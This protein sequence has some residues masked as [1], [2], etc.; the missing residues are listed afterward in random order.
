M[1]SFYRRHL[2]PIV[3]GTVLLAQ[4]LG[5]AIQVKR[6][7]DQGSSSVLRLWAVAVFSPIERRFVHSQNWVGDTWRNYFYLR[8]VRKENEELKARLQQLELEQI[9]LREDAN[10]ARRIQSLLQFKEQYINK[11]VAAQVIGTSGSEQ[12]RMIYID[13]GSNDGIKENL[14][15]ISPAGIVGKV[16]RVFPDYSQVLEITDQTSGV[17]VMLTKTRLQGILR[18]TPSGELSLNYIMADEKIES[19]EEIVTSGGDRIF[20]KGLPVG[21]V[22]WTSPGRDMFLSVRVRPSADLNRLEEVLVITETD[23]REPDTKDLGPIR[24]ADI[25]AERLPSVPAKPDPN[26]PAANAPAPGTT[27]PTPAP[28]Q[29]PA[30]TQQQAAPGSNRPAPATGTAASRPSANATAPKPTTGSQQH[31]VTPRPADTAQQGTSSAQ[32]PANT[33]GTAAG[34][35]KPATPRPQTPSSTQGSGVNGQAKPK[36]Q[37]PAPTAQTPPQGH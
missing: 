33:T 1:D 17:G 31:P 29:A 18:G 37:T 14:P 16:L 15:V 7:T 21:K 25:L 3:L 36:S 22:M 11:T 5:L 32:R 12:S 8:G 6:P 26:A 35:S 13:R 24:A 9:R 27:A 19:G 28:Q 20:P 34:Q 30:T 2:N 10:Q 4:L 23:K